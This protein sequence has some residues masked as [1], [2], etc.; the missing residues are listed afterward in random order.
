M[1]EKKYDQLWDDLILRAIT[2]YTSKHSDYE[3]AVSEAELKVDIRNAYEKVYKPLFKSE[4][5]LDDLE[6]IDDVQVDGG[7][8][9]KI[10]RH[11][12]AAL[13]Y[14]SIVCNDNKP[15]IRLKNKQDKNS[16]LSILACHEIAYSISLNCISSFIAESHRQNPSC[17]HKNNF[18]KN[19]GFLKSPSLICERYSSYKASII[20][21]MVWAVETNDNKP[22]KLVPTNANM[23]ANIF[24]FLELHSA[25]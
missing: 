13:L 2:N 24:Y 17:Q 21:R 7:K 19:N 9:I 25:S 10:D 4:Y 14:L 15:F 22:R 20:P 6:S 16:E 23:L 12:V 8:I 1:T 18:R 5:M 11:K 3:L